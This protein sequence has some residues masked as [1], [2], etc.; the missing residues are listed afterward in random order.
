MPSPLEVL[1]SRIA[2]FVA[3]LLLVV[4]MSACGNSSAPAG[5]DVASLSGRTM[6]GR[7][8]D[9]IGAIGHIQAP[10]GLAAAVQ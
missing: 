6:T 2:R 5:R 8:V 7:S 9:A 4:G 1:V 10:T 3:P